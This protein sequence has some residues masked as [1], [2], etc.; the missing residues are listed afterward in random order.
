LINFDLNSKNQILVNPKLSEQEQQVILQ[1]HEEFEKEFGA[2]NYVLVPSSG[3]SKRTGQSI[4]LIALQISRILNSANRVNHY[5][6]ATDQDQ[7][8][9]VLPE[10]HVAGIGVL[11]RA[12]LMQ[13]KVF[14]FNW[15]AQ[16]LFQ[17]LE[18][19]KISYLSL[20]PAQVFDLIQSEVQAPSCLKT[21]FVGG[22]ALTLEQRKRFVDLGWPVVETYG[23]TETC[24]MIAVREKDNDLFHLLNNVYVKAE[25]KK[26]SIRCDSLLTATIQK[27]ENKVQIKYFD[28]NSWYESEDQVDLINMNSE[29]YLRFLGRDQDYLKILGEGVS[30]A[31]LRTLLSRIVMNYKLPV[32]SFEIVDLEDVRAGS[33]LFLAAENN[34]NSEIVEKVFQDFNRQC[35]AYEKLKQV[36]LVE[37]IPRTE[38]GKLKF[39]NLKALVVELL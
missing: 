36:V 13:S 31:E 2:Y 18:K 4:K 26:L 20:V 3:S 15:S 28:E 14:K 22:G 39:E 17:N 25:E 12:Y 23:M 24:S 11:A 21:V 32:L 27:N 7:W 33:R 10:F 19:N 37:K 16:S 30:L 1:L 29:V 34:I 8:G 38:L 9:L 35:R 6:K 5:L